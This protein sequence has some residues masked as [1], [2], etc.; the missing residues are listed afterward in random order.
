MRQDLSIATP[1]GAM[2]AFAFTPH[3]GEGPWPAVILLLDAAA[4]RPA[5]F[6]MGERL[7]QAGYFVVLPDLF[8]RLGDYP[9]AKVV[10]IMATDETRRAAFGRTIGSTSPDKAMSDVGAVLDWLVGQ[11]Q[12]RGRKVGVAGYCFGGSVAIRAAAA[13]PDRVAAAASFHGGGMVTAADNSPH[14]LAPRIRARVLVAG[15]DADPGYTEEQ[16]A[17]FAEALKDAGVDADVSIWNGL[18]HGW[19]PADMPVHSPEG[20]ERHWRALTGLLDET[21]A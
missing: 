10:E 2:R 1:D 5:L 13:F 17:R 7:A 20:A 8:W 3:R 15:A 18:R 21:L 11:P 16:D 19:V 12:A 9:P 4:I 6:D 14:R